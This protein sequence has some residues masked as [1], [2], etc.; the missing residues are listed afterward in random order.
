MMYLRLNRHRVAA[1]SGEPSKTRD[2][3]GL[4]HSNAANRNRDT[5]HVHSPP[6]SQGY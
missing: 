2:E 6:N 5:F 1:Q 3:F 4:S